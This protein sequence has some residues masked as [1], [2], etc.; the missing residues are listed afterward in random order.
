MLRGDDDREESERV[1]APA[2]GVAADVAADGDAN[3][4]A[5][6]DDLA[7]AP[8]EFDPDDPVCGRCED[9]DVLVDADGGE[10]QIAQGASVPKAPSREI[11]ARDN[12]THLPYAS[13][14]PWCVMGRRNN[15]PHFRSKTGPDRRLPLLVVDYAFVRDKEDA[16]LC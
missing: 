12:L 14:C 2:D 15:S 3:Q 1:E 10:Y 13:W 11:Q 6:W 16:A 5:G 4:D 9:D 8:L 7:E